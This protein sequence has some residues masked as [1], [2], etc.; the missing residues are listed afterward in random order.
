MDRSGRC[1][2][3]GNCT[4]ANQKQTIVMPAGL[5]MKCPEC[6]RSLAEV[7]DGSALRRPPVD[8]ASVPFAYDPET[9]TVSVSPQSA[10]W[11]PK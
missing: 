10:L 6:G 3:F 2:N 8:E 4:T 7:T 5:E 9:G 11:R 1:V